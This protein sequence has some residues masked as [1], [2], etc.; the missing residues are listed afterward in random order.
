MARV[1]SEV[2]KEAKTPLATDKA[3]MTELERLKE[4]GNRPRKVIQIEERGVMTD[5]GDRAV[6]LGPARGT[7]RQRTSA[8]EVPPAACSGP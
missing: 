3:E 7:V 6:I 2:Q 4:D 8:K 5:T 1:D